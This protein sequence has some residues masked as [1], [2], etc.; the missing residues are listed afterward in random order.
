VVRRIT[1]W[2]KEF[3]Y[4][5]DATAAV[6]NN[7]LVH[8][9]LNQYGVVQLPVWFNIGAKGRKAQASACFILDVKTLWSRLRSGYKRS[10][11]IPWRIGIRG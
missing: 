10:R 7:E 3:G 1:N 5:D 8:I 2:G 9:L 11:G 4:F 6:F